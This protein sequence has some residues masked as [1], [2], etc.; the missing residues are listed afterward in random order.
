MAAACRATRDVVRVKAPSGPSAPR[1]RA[2][3]PC[4]STRRSRSLDYLPAPALGRSNVAGGPGRP[5]PGQVILDAIRR[6]TEPFGHPAPADRGSDL[7]RWRIRFRVV[8]SLSRAL[9]RVPAPVSR[10][11]APSSGAVSW[12]V[13]P[14]SWVAAWVSWVVVSVS[15]VVLFSFARL[16][17]SSRSVNTTG[18]PASAARRILAT[19]LPA[20]SNSG[21]RRPASTQRSIMSSVPV[22][23]CSMYLTRYIARAT[24]GLPGTDSCGTRSRSSVS[25]GWSTPGF[26]TS[27]RELALHAAH[28]NADGSHVS[29]GVSGSTSHARPGML[30]RMGAARLHALVHHTHPSTSRSS[31]GPGRLARGRTVRYNAGD[32]AVAPRSVT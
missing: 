25:G 28:E 11:L 5:Q 30:V 21:S 31:R 15:W 23:I 22:P 10:A 18:C 26:Q 9:F 24:N 19:K 13:A 8:V 20:V 3:P 6:D 4:S 27:F 17:T 32:G 12:V 16:R 14:I 1:S 29:G 2:R 7:S